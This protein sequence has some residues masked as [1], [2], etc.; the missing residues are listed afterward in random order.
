MKWRITVDRIAEY[1]IVPNM[2]LNPRVLA[3]SIIRK[4]STMY[5]V[6]CISLFM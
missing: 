2:I 4:W 1:V 6:M 5:G 3:S